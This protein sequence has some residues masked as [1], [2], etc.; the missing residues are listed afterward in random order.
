MNLLLEKAEEIKQR[1]KRNM[2]QNPNYFN[3]IEKNSNAKT[4]YKE[5]IS[6]RLQQR[7]V[8]N[9]RQQYSSEVRAKNSKYDMTKM[10]VQ[11]NKWDL[12][13]RE[14]YIIR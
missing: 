2:L 14:V 12:K 9:M 6:T 7:V 1:R 4:A 3:T 8:D 5:F 13:R 11:I 10:I